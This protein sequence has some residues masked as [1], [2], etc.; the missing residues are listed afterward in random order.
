M[1]KDF[2]QLKLSSVICNRSTKRS[3]RL[4][5]INKAIKW[6]RIEKILK[7]EYS[8]GKSK[9]GRKSYPALVLF[10]MLLIGIWYNLSDYEVE[11]LCSD[12]ISFS[13]FIGIPLEDR[14]PDHSVLSRFR[15]EIAKKGVLERLMK[16]IEEQF[17]EM[18]VMVK[19]GEVKIVDAS[20]TESRYK[21]KG[22]KRY[23]VGKVEGIEGEDG[24]NNGD[25]DKRERKEGEGDRGEGRKEG[26]EGVEGGIVRQEK[27][28][29][30]LEESYTGGSYDR[31]GGWIKK[32]NKIYYGYKRHIIVNKDG[33]IL[34]VHTTAANVSDT[35]E[36]KE[37]VKKSGCKAGDKIYADKGYDS[38]EN[39]D[40]LKGMGIKERIMRRSRRGRGEGRWN[41]KRNKMISKERYVIERTFG[42]IKLWFGGWKARYRGMIKVHFQHLMEAIGYNLYRLP[43][44][45]VKVKGEIGGRRA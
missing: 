6:D 11:E 38:K 26:R 42:G 13:K 16:E 10:K 19:E 29:G 28:N 22:K 35:T 39:R 40:F 1:Q 4:E 32:G 7:E 24:W 15:S 14:V 25:M 2:T 41:E 21:P 23:E 12:C 5:K 30:H 34:G 20:I 33:L 17:V 27:G 31:E 36:M 8:K 43:Y 37:L 3:V 18:G 9:E 44:L 45:E